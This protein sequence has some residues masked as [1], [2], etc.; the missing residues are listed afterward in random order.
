MNRIYKSIYHAARRCVVCVSEI[1]SSRVKT[2]SEHKG[3]PV[4]LILSMLSSAV[5]MVVS[6]TSMAAPSIVMAD[7]GGISY[8]GNGED[9]NTPWRMTDSQTSLK[10]TW[11]YVIGREM[12]EG[13]NAYDQGIGP[14]V[15]MI[16]TDFTLYKSLA[17]TGVGNLTIEKGS[18]LNISGGSSSS[19]YAFERLSSDGGTAEIINEG[20]LT[21]QGG[22]GYTSSGIKGLVW[23]STNT[24]TIKNIGTG[25]LTISGGTG[26]G[27]YGIEYTVWNDGTAVI[28]N[29][30][31]GDLI[32]QGGT[33][34]EAHGI[35]TNV[36]SNGTVTIT[37][38]GSGSLT[39]QGGTG[40]YSTGIETNTYCS[41]CTG[42]ISNTGD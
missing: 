35:A 5:L 18:T 26:R 1:Q 32:I 29:E 22:S 36:R 15:N 17:D 28:S 33:G 40:L 37:N 30:S 38:I 3:S 23:G 24:S 13:F 34:R 20:T 4:K 25:T 41:G 27:A 10:E 12:F 21:I 42:T 11:S 14:T 8:T 6:S 7:I 16:A 19:T 39:I 31:E 9:A 2:K